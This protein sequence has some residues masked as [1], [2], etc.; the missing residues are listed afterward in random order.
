MRIAKSNLTCPKKRLRKNDLNKIFDDVTT[1]VA[2]PLF[3]RI[4]FCQS[5]KHFVFYQSHSCV[6][7]ADFYLTRAE[8][9]KFV[10]KFVI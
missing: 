6:Q 2:E 10:G 7:N 4:M 9:G 8:D 3:N 1:L 5:I